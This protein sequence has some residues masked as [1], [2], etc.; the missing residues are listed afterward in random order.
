[1]E[2]ENIIIRE[3]TAD[4]I[5][6]IV[7]INKLA[8]A[9]DAE[10][11]LV[12]DLLDDKTAKPLLSL[13]AIKE[14]EPVGH[15]LFT[16]VCFVN[17]ENQP[18]MYLLAPLAVKPSNHGN[19][20]GGRLIKEGREMLKTRGA[21]LVFVLGHEKYYPKYGFKPDAGNLGFEAPYPIPEE[22]AGAWMFQFLKDEKNS[23]GSHKI[24]CANKLDKPE[25][26]RE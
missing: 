18:L 20:I 23:Y 12:L 15:I 19:G 5:N 2:P 25:Y 6:E 11:N 13:L 9:S 21:E 7:D 1:M 22:N 10:A 4:D 3:T 17:Q 14:N 24:R 26:W 8:F 16:K